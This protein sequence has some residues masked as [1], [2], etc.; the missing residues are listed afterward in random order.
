MA[1]SKWKKLPVPVVLL[2]TFAI[3]TQVQGQGGP[4]GGGP[5]AG[6]PLTSGG[7]HNDEE[8]P[9]PKTLKER[10]VKGVV[11]DADGN[12]VSGAVVQLKNTRTMQ[13]RSLITHEKGDYLFTGLSKDV[14][15]EV[16]A[17]YKDQSSDP[18][19]LSKLDIRAQPVVNLKLK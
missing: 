13:I 12:P 4:G 10:P 6:I 5:G 7:S 18:H 8:K 15:Y 1:I 2:A 17:V 11:T 14:D 9:D 16:K 3:A 19:T